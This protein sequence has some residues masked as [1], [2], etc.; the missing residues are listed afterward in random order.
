MRVLESTTDLQYEFLRALYELAGGQARR[1][2]FYGDISAELGRSPE[3]AEQA[4][5]FW[6]DR[7]MLDWVT[8]G[9]VALTHIGVRRAE[10]LASRGWCSV[11]F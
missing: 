3:E 1:P 11:P 9:H 4:C 8:L 7:G 10:R 5:E 2:V 6:A